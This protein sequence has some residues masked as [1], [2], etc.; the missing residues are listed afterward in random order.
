MQTTALS[1]DP[2]RCPLCGGDNRCA[3][4]VEKA[5]GK[6]Q[7]PCWCVTETFTPDLLARL[8]AEAQGQA[9]ICARCLARFNANTQES[10]P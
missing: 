3:M 5:T 6:P 4:E 7:P 1:I 2:T 10:P 9:C 8:P